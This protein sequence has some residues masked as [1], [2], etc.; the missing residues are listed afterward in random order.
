MFEPFEGVPDYP[1]LEK[2]VTEFWETREIFRKLREQT[3]GGD[4]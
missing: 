1:A 3:E 2:Q 4:L